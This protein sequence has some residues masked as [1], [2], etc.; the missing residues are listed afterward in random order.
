M[1]RGGVGRSNLILPAIKPRPQLVRNKYNSDPYKNNVVLFLKGDGENNSTN[2]VDSSLTPKIITRFGDT[3]IS[4]TQSKY[5]GSSIYFDGNGDYLTA[6]CSNIDGD[7]TFDVW[8]HSPFSSGQVLMGTWST[9]NWFWYVSGTFMYF[10][11]DTHYN[12]TTTIPTNTWVHL[13]ASRQAGTVRYFVNGTQIATHANSST[14]T[15]ASSTFRIGD[16]VSS[17]P[18]FVGYMDS[19][20]ITTGI[21]RY[22]ANFNPETD[23][24]LDI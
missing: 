14:L 5:G 4:T 23:T 18:P 11:I 10:Y 21:A 12:N 9:G 19:L 6:P 1:I 22:T 7:F 3:K 15:M 20:R 24:F 2:I 16:R 17:G 13:A 8:V